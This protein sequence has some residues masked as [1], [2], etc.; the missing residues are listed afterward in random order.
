MSLGIVILPKKRSW[1]YFVSKLETLRWL[2][3]RVPA[4]VTAKGTHI[5]V[6]GLSLLEMRTPLT[7]VQNA[8]SPQRPT[9]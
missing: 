1:K 3:D 5:K 7:C 6:Q 8:V 2:A 9:E 4:R